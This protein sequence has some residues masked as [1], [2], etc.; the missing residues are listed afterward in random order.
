MAPDAARL[1]A[2]A[3]AIS[4]GQPLDWAEAESS[5]ATDADRALVRELRLLAGLADAHR[6]ATEDGPFAAGETTEAFTRWGVLEIRERLG[7]GTFGTVYRAWDPRLAREVALKVLIGQHPPDGPVPEV[8]DEGRLLARVRHPHVITVYGADRVDGRIGIWMELVQGRT[9][10]DL[11]RQQ[12]SFSAREATSILAELCGAVAAVHRAGLVHR[13]IKAQNV[14]REDG[15]RLVLMD[16]GAGQELEPHASRGRVV[17]T[18]VY[19]AP[20]LFAGA[21]ATVRSD[22]YSLGVLLFHIVTGEYPVAARTSSGVEQAHARL[23]YRRLI[24]LRP[25]LP[26]AFIHLVECALATDPEQRFES[27]GAI[28]AALSRLFAQGGQQDRLSS[29]A[30]PRVTR[31]TA[32]LAGV[33]AA[34]AL[35]AALAAVR[36]GDRLPWSGRPEAPKVV[37][38]LPMA[39]LSK[40]DGAD[41]FAEGVT[42]ILMN[43][44]AMVPPLSVIA[45]G[46]ISGLPAGERDPASL[47]RKLGADYTVEGSVN[48]QPNRVRVTARLIQAST[49]KLLWSDTF[50]RPIADLFAVQGEIA[51]TIATQIGA[52]LTG[53]TRRR[54]EARETTSAA[55]QDAYLRGR[56]LLY[57]FNSARMREARALF[58][59]AVAL[60][61]GYALAHAS[62]SRTYGMMLDFD[63][64]SAGELEPLA[65]AAAERG[66][67]LNPELLETNVAHA[68]AQF[69]FR[70]D[71]DAADAAYRR[72]LALA[73]YSSLVLSPYARFLCAAGRLAEAD[74]HARRGAQSDPLSA[75]MI[76]SVG[77]VAY[78]RRDFDEALRWHQRAAEL[79]PTHGPVHMGMARALAAKG[80]YDR[81]IE[82][83]KRALALVGESHGYQA[84]LAR[85]YAARGWT[86]LAEQTLGGLL[87]AARE[88]RNVPYEGIGYVYAALGR[89]DQAFE[90]LNRSL[91]HYFARMLFLKV[92]PRADPIRDDP[93]YAALLQRLGL[94]P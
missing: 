70:H 5:S 24:D 89:R 78:Y 61:P 30:P 2:L 3:E 85:I 68:D 53:D 23:E 28:E 38:V 12:G 35:L 13:D 62:L 63:L 26:S 25:D 8:V 75:E 43:R 15:G 45:R 41:Y 48:R 47:R 27:A 92:D 88:G 11:V 69:R 51:A 14:M 72:A 10:E 36:F 39:N 94:Q 77:V 21:P 82:S 29:D 67:R 1:L 71:W 93:R 80:D 50:E 60:D 42:E 17:G 22:I 32:V 31:R 6:T 34:V 44:L 65:I 20:E 4:D 55:A 18:P 59:E 81:A 46:S 37:V 64:A 49:G 16:F 83:I 57:R 56:Y 91:E 74:R 40:E 54:L 7:S 76:T 9:L 33:S 66:F 86:E 84:E 58:E 90:W 52:K 79:S 73:P 87:V 19:M